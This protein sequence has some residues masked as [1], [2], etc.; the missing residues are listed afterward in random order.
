MNYPSTLQVAAKLALLNPAWRLVDL[1][2]THQQAADGGRQA[3]ERAVMG[4]N[5]KAALA[6]VNA[7]GE[8]AETVGTDSHAGE[9]MMMLMMWRLSQAGHHPD[10][11]IYGWNK[12]AIRHAQ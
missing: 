8:V 4:K 11:A 5:F 7:L 9:M 1:H 12:V 10:L 2:S 3:L 6:I